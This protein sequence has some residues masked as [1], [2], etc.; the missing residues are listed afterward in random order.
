MKLSI[1]DNIRTFRKE[2]NITQEQLAEIL[3]VSCQ[4]ISRWELGICYPDME[5]LPTLA[6]FFAATIDQ[7]L[8]LEKSVEQE[9]VENYLNRFQIAISQ[10]KIKDCITIAREGVADYPNNYTLLNKLMYALFVSGDDTGNIENFEEN[11]KRYDDEITR[12]GERI[13]KYCSDQEIRLEAMARLAF[14]H[15]EQGRKELG[16]KIYEQLPS[17]TL[18]RENQMWW[19][20]EE[21]EK[22]PFLQKQIKESSDILYKYLWLLGN[23]GKLS[24]ADSLSVMNK[25]EEL[26][27]LIAEQKFVTYE[28]IRLHYDK[29]RLYSQIGDTSQA[30]K[31]LSI[32]AKQADEFDN[33][34]ETQTVHSS[35]IGKITIHH[36]DFETA[37]TRSVKEIFMEEWL[38]N[39][40]F[41]S[42]RNTD[43]FIVLEHFLK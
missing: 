8:G 5:L 12:L 33:R 39:P 31:E 21:E 24:Y 29:A 43:E 3:N 19:G 18:C 14:H 22:L 35:L 9:K 30:C 15:C 1:G 41:D 40:A 38:N 42:I 23:S 6:E 37:D 2:K 27:N 36:A 10:G 25:G 13:M 4:S 20:L 28:D 16:R 32:A 34:P 17:M 7:L 11:A 26:R